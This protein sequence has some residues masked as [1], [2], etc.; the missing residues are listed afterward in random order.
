VCISVEGIEWSEKCR[1]F[2]M[3]KEC[4]IGGVCRSI[5]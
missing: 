1:A 2:V 5:P 3:W 4:V